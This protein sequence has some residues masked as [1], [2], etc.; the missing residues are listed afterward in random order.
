MKKETTIS[1]EIKM[2]FVNV[3]EV[4]QL[5]QDQMMMVTVEG[6]RILLANVD[7]AYYAIDNKCSHLGGSLANGDLSGSVVTCPRHGAQFDVRTGNTV[8]KA[9]IA[10]IKMQVKDQ[11][12]YQVKIEGEN[13]LLGVPE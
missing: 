12:S 10:M 2:K 3:A 1:K 5:P 6:K 4:S 11:E 9:K 8:G 7:G 13:I